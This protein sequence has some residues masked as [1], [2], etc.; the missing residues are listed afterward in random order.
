[1][2]GDNIEC[3]DLQTFDVKKGG[4]SGYDVCKL[5]TKHKRHELLQ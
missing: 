1:M 3:A 5:R 4:N 2:V